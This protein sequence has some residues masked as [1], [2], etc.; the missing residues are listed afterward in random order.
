VT[1]FKTYSLSFI[2]SP[3]VL[4]RQVAGLPFAA[5]QLHLPQLIQFLEL[6]ISPRQLD[7]G[8]VWPVQLS[9]AQE[10]PLEQ[11]DGY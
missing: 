7:P 1:S 11:R 8:Q 6:Q 3:E 2:F 9:Q 10:C 4:L 5:S